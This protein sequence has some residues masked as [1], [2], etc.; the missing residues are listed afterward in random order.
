MNSKGFKGASAHLCSSLPPKKK[1]KKKKKKSAKRK[2]AG[3]NRW[4]DYYPRLVQ[5]AQRDEE[6][7]AYACACTRARAGEKKNFP[8]LA[9]CPNRRTNYHPE[10]QQSVPFSSAR[11]LAAPP[12]LPRTMRISTLHFDLSQPFSLSVCKRLHGTPTWTRLQDLRPPS[13]LL[14]SFP[15]SL[16]VVL[17]EIPWWSCVYKDRLFRLFSRRRFDLSLSLF[18]SRSIH[19][20]RIMTRETT[21][22]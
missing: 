6:E 13:S 12:F 11:I 21:W 19:L 17:F 16:R 4:D 5:R 3:W 10:S 8:R 15:F 7:R 9:N 14:A 1:R 20:D 22:I 18:L 2:N